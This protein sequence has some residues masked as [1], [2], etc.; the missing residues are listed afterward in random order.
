MIQ[1]VLQPPPHM[2]SVEK[3]KHNI[4]LQQE[5]QSE[6]CTFATIPYITVTDYC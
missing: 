4:V 2:K 1:T 5:L 3:Y 6:V